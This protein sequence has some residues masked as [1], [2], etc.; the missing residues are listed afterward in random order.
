[1]PI[2]VAG[3]T[4]ASL[5]FNPAKVSDTGDYQVR[6]TSSGGST[7]S[8]T[9]RLTVNAVA[10]NPPVITSPPFD[11]TVSVGGTATLSVTAT[12]NGLAYQWRKGDQALIGETSPAL[13]VNPVNA[14]SGGTYT[15][16]VSNAGGAVEAS[17]TL[18]VAPVIISQSGSPAKI[19]VGETLRLSVTANGPAPLTYQWFRNDSPLGTGTAADLVISSAAAN[20]AGTYTV[21]VNA[22]GASVNGNPVMVE[23]RSLALTAPQ[24]SGNSLT[25]GWSAI[26]GRGYRIEGNAG[27]S[28]AWT[29]SG[30][31]TASGESATFNA[32]ADAGFGFF[33]LVPQ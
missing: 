12:G 29:T 19:H 32:P 23:V 27:L 15:V 33:R 30:E 28:G 4:N 10:V 16:R 2:T 11:A 9:A 25:I 18:T 17:A 5:T 22:P 24:L 1:M 6:V 21:R 20:D 3:A 7:L 8:S 31:V 13:I 14:T 26:V